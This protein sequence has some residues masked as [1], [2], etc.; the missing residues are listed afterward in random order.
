MKKFFTSLALI[1]VMVT[2]GAANAATIEIDADGTLEI[3]VFANIIESFRI[4]ISAD[5]LTLAG[6]A[7][8]AL[9]IIDLNGGLAGYDAL[10][11]VAA[12]ACRDDSNLPPVF[13]NPAS[14]QCGVIG[15]LTSAS[16]SLLEFDVALDVK[17]EISGTALVDLAVAMSGL[18][19]ADAVFSGQ[20]LSF[21]SSAA[22]TVDG[23]SDQDT[24]VLNWHGEAA[25]NG[26]PGYDDTIIV[27][28]T[29]QP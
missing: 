10:K 14:V 21:A 24:D 22:V 7:P 28:V 15:G 26:G 3:N 11:S 8:T 6:A 27:T 1:A 19:Q 20:V 13:A 23:M 12:A 16:D 18:S 17:A 25:L 9:G 29:K 2:G 4:T 5:D